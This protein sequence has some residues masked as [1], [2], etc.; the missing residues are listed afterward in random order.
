MVHVNHV[1]ELFS[2]MTEGVAMLTGWGIL[3]DVAVTP[4][5]LSALFPVLAPFCEAFSSSTQPAEGFF[6]P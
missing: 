5:P 6:H 1:D 2:N 3:L 4:T